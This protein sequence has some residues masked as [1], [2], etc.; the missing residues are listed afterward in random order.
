MSGPLNSIVVIVYAAVLAVL[1][2]AGAWWAAPICGVFGIGFGY[3]GVASL[4]SG[5]GQKKTGDLE[6]ASKSP[7]L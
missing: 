4:A 2:A 7:V 6:S 3:V 5:I 1:L